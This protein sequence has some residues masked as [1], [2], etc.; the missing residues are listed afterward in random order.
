MFTLIYIYIQYY[1]INCKAERNN[2]LVWKKDYYDLLFIS[3]L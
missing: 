1:K 2:N 3:F